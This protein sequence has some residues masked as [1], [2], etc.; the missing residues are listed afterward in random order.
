MGGCQSL[1]KGPDR[2]RDIALPGNAKV[3]P[4]GVPAFLA[5][6]LLGRRPDIVAA[7][8]RAAAAASRIKVAHAA[9][10]P[11]IDLTGNLGQQSFG[12]AD[13]FN[14]A[15]RIGQIGPAISLPVFD[16]GRIEG[17]YRNAR[18]EYDEAVATYDKTLTG[19]L[20]E[21]ADALADQRELAAE[22]GHSRASLDASQSAWRVASLRYKAGLSRYLEVLT[23]ED[24]LVAQRRTVADLTAKSFAQDVALV[25]ALGGGFVFDEPQTITISKE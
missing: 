25:Q 21:V 15:S 13:L 20:R 19:A 10:Y 3:A 23:A 1:G 14:P 5:A 6:D 4:F 12:I 8:L 17:T 2:G 24:T 9:F 18:A 22:L 11:N 7:R 16:G